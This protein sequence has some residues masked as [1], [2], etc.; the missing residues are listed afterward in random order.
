MSTSPIVV[1]DTNI[2]LKTHLLRSPVGAAT[3]FR[4]HLLGAKIC[5]PEVVEEELTRNVV[6]LGLDAIE[7]IWA[8]GRTLESLHGELGMFDLPTAAALKASVVER[9]RELD[10]YILRVPFAMEHARGALIKVLDGVPPCGPK[11][12]QFKDAAIWEAVLCLGR[13]RDIYF[14]TADTDYL[15][16][17]TLASGLAPNLLAEV[18]AA[19]IRLRLFGDLP[20]CLNSLAAT[21]IPNFPEARIRSELAKLVQSELSVI[22]E[23]EDGISFGQV[24]TELKPV[25]SEDADKISMEFVVRRDFADT[26][27]PGKAIGEATVEGEAVYSLASRRLSARISGPHIRRFMG[28]GRGIIYIGPNE[29][30]VVVVPG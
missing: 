9:L 11:N 23:A 20:S 4:L 2:W 13:G 24:E 30:R 12:Q 22:M 29:E 3:L 21:P 27:A 25:S 18:D 26:Q 28:G 5:L 10:S 6:R 19:G 7:K 15:K 8:Q 17:K 16:D 1:L 14:V